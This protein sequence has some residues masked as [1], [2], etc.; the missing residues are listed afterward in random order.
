ML[1][2][3]ALQSRGAPNW[4]CGS[5][6]GACRADLGAAHGGALRTRG[7]RARFEGGQT[8]TAGRHAGGDAA[9]AR[10]VRRCR[11]RRSPFTCTPLVA[12]LRAVEHRGTA[13]RS[14]LSSQVASGRQTGRP[15]RRGGRT[16]RRAD[17]RR[18]RGPADTRARSGRGRWCGRLHGA[19]RDRRRLFDLRAT[20]GPAR[21][22][23]AASPTCTLRSQIVSS[24]S[25]LS[26]NVSSRRQS[27]GGHSGSSGGTTTRPA[28]SQVRHSR[29]TQPPGGISPSIGSPPPLPPGP[30]APPRPWRGVEESRTLRPG[31]RAGVGRGAALGAIVGL[32]AAESSSGRGAPVSRTACAHVERHADP[33]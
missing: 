29:G 23:V 15:R 10:C 27:R 3:M 28:A 7:V 4:G 12:D 26:V 31:L 30:S 16:A 6:N 17:G 33:A 2:S 11:S 18:G 21:R 22:S 13:P 25:V 19:G 24:P 32:G 14:R 20:F 9:R 1:S 8:Q 5:G